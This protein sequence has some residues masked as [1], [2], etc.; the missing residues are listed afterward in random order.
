[1]TGGRAL[2]VL[3]AIAGG[4]ALYGL[5]RLGGYFASAA[6]WRHVPL[7]A[8][9]LT[10]PAARTIDW[11]ETSTQTQVLVADWASQPLPDWQDEGKVT[12]PRVL[13]AKLALGVDLDAVNAYLQAQVPWGRSGS[14]RELHSEGTTTSTAALTAILYSHGDDETRALPGDPGTPPP[15]PSPPPSTCSW[16]KRAAIRVSLSQGPRPGARY[17]EPP[18]YDRR[19]AIPQE[20]L[21]GAPRQYR[22]PPR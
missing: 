10:V 2:R 12:A 14:T 21:A 13:M 11:R 22:P 4:A 8:G 20:P 6:R 16:S 5:L 19:S 7:P 17:R 1:M 15:P 9:S 18:P 3:A